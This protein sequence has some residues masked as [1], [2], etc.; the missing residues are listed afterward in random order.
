MKATKILKAEHLL[1]LEAL[2]SF[3]AARSRLESREFIVTNYFEKVIEF[4]KNFSDKF[5]HFKEEF[6]L[7]GLLAQKKN[8]D[9]DL[10]MGALRYQH[11]RNRFFLKNIEQSLEGYDLNNEIVATTLLENLTSYIS[12]LRRH[13]HIEDHLL[14]NLADQA[15]NEEENRSLLK[16]F[17]IE[18][19]KAGGN[20]FYEY[21]KRL[22]A[23]MHRMIH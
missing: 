20:K 4:S 11:E 18:D 3:V 16:Q 2:D 10:E 13:I 7:F 6:L 1:I 15:L 12:I 17:E 21:S 5:H 23:E 14:F 22:V 19:Q 8:G 9:L